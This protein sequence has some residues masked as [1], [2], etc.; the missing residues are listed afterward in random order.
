MLVIMRVVLLV[1]LL[2]LCACGT[3]SPSTKDIMAEGKS[4]NMTPI[5]PESPLSVPPLLPP[6]AG[7]TVTEKASATDR[8]SG[9]IRS[10]EEVSAQIRQVYS[11]VLDGMT[12]KYFSAYPDLDKEHTQAMRE[13]ILRESPPDTFVTLMLSHYDHPHS[14]DMQEIPDAKPM[15]KFSDND[16]MVAINLSVCMAQMTIDQERAVYV[17]KFIVK[18]PIQL[19]LFAMDTEKEFTDWIAMVGE[20]VTAEAFIAEC[21]KT[22]EDYVYQEGDRFFSFCSSQETW[23]NL[24]GRQGY[25]IVRDGKIVQSIVTMLN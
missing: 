12:L 10:R 11:T 16:A 13:F 1:P 17:A 23:E 2:F 24:C 18:N 6:P 15:Q 7:F 9:G 3:T 19:E 5:P 4:Q 25:L 20:E 8:E 14:P 22:Y 21:G